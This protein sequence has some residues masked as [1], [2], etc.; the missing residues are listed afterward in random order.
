LEPGFLFGWGVFE[1]LRVYGGKP[2]FLN[3]HLERLK[4][5][6][7]FIGLDFPVLDFSAEIDNLLKK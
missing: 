6:V 2:A 1:T 3:E 7:E 4:N 5:G